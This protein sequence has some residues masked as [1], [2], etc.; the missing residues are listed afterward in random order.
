MAPA[1][2]VDI[3]GQHRCSGTDM[4]VTC[5]SVTLGS[6]GFGPAL[7]RFQDETAEVCD[8]GPESFWFQN[9]LDVSDWFHQ[10]GATVTLVHGNLKS[11]I[12]GTQINHHG[13][14]WGKKA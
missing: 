6:W 12:K 13:N 10:F 11:F 5:I 7:Q 9:N 4:G 8:L 3:K 2:A 1:V 14:N